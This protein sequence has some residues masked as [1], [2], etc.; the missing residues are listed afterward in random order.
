MSFFDMLLGN[1]DNLMDKDIA[2]D[3]IKDSKFGVT[4]LSAA[5]VEAVNPVLRKRLQHQLDKAVREHFELTDIL[6]NKG[7]Y[8]AFDMPIEQVRKEYNETQSLT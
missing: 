5:A 6:I 2:R 7:W 3:M 4:S 1:N 8:P